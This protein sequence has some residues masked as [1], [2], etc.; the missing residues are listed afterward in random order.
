MRRSVE[1]ERSFTALVAGAIRRSLIN[2]AT[3]EKWALMPAD[4]F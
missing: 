1:Q 4:I 3:S 2:I